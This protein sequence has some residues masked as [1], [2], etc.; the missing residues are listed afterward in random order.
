MKMFALPL[1]FLF[2]SFSPIE[3][4]KKIIYYPNGN[5]HFEYEV[6][7]G[8]LNGPVT[9]YYENGKIKLQGQ[10]KNNQKTGVWTSW[11]EKGTKRSQRKFLDDYSFEI[12]NEW[13]STGRAIDPEIIQQKNERLIGARSKAIVGRQSR[14]IHRFWREIKPG[15]PVNNFLFENNSFYDFLITEATN[16]RMYVYSEDRF[17]N[18]ITDYELLKSYKGATVVGYLL[19]EE[20]IFTRDKEVMH[21]V[22]FGICPVVSV[23]GENKQVG[24]FYNTNIRNNRQATDAIENIISRLEKRNYSSIVT[25][26]TLNAAPKKEREVQVADSDLCLLAPFEWEAQVW[27]YFMDKQL[28]AK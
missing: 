1:A 13:D 23:N 2:L 15:E 17:I 7:T 25:K 8:L 22:V 12:I 21:T 16:K 9:A 6:K 14:Y 3:I 20:L 10:I 24:W 11:D 27:I 26:T 28:V 18:K 5:K 4:E 19:K